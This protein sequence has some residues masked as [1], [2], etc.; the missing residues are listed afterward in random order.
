MIYAFDDKCLALVGITNNLLDCMV[1]VERKLPVVHLQRPSEVC[2]VLEVVRKVAENY[3]QRA[4]VVVV[5][6]WL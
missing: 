5:D 4:V 6:T 2:F 1:V 3:C